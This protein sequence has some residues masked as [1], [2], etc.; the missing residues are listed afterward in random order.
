MIKNILIFHKKNPEQTP[1]WK[2]GFYG[3]VYK[4]EP[5]HGG[6]LYRSHAD[7]GV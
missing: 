2:G 3:R 7:G 6:T 4:R 1:D 5:L